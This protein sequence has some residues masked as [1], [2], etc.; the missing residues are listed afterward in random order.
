M[1]HDGYGVILSAT[2][3]P[4]MVSTTCLV[5]DSD[6][7]PDTVPGMPALPEHP[8]RF[9]LVDSITEF[10]PGT[11][12]TAVKNLTR[13]EEYLGDH[14]P[15]FPVMP[16]VLMLESLVQTGAWVIREATGFQFSTILL[17]EVK[18]L[19]LKSFVAPGDQ[20]RITAEKFKSEENDWTF[21][22]SGSVGENEVV[23]ARLILRQFNLADGNPRFSANDDRMIAHFRQLWEELNPPRISAE[24]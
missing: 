12:I 1:P 19:R 16:G 18:A 7:L 10:T 4:G 9:T 24:A 13:A 11:S 8:V 22:A 2:V 14:F 20:L 21:K 6:K 5:A 23:S 3:L 17:K 15:G